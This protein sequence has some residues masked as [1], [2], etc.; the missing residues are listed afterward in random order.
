MRT[1]QVRDA[2]QRLKPDQRD[3]AGPPRLSAADH[4][5]S[6]LRTLLTQP[7]DIEVRRQLRAL[8]EFG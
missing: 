3:Q 8:R 2:A 7:R 4:T 6:E 5:T 1:D